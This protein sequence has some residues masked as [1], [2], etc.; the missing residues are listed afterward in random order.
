[1]RTVYGLV[2]LLSAYG[3][4]GRRTERVC[5]EYVRYLVNR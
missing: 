4:K 1:M 5:I 2:C 3:A